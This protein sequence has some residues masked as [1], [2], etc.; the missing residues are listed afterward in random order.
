MQFE[1]LHDLDEYF[2]EKYASYDKLC[3]LKGYVMPKMQATKRLPDGRDYAYTLPASTMRLATQPKKAELLSALK[4]KLV[5]ASFSFSF[6]PVS[7]WEK[8]TRGKKKQPFHKVLPQ[9][10]ARKNM[11]KEELFGA[12]SVD[13]KVFERIWKGTYYPTKN[14]IFSIA[15]A[16]HLSEEDTMELMRARELVFDFSAHKDVVVAYLISRSVFNGEMIKA[17]LKEYKI[18]GLFLKAAQEPRLDEEKQPQ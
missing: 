9:V 7:L 6:R 1:F 15:L 17:A 12:L 14:M 10:L 13:K 2:C 3:V 16:A 4:E 5:D 11:T 18:D 8:M